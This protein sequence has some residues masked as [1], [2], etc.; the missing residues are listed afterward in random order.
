M[1][2]SGRKS[3]RMASRSDSRRSACAKTAAGLRLRRWPVARLSSASTA[4]PP[5]TSAST[6]C[7]PMKPAPPVTRQRRE[8]SA[9]AGLPDLGQDAVPGELELVAGVI[10]VSLEI[11]DDRLRRGQR[12]PAVDRA[13]R[14][15]DHERP[16]HA[17]HEGV[18]LAEGRR[19]APHVGDRDLQLT[20]RA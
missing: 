7:E 4:W 16:L 19:A 8:R 9:V 6:M 12:L 3:A 10:D 13:G 1:T 14:D 17:E 20:A 2:T 15:L 11:D 5:S 18:D